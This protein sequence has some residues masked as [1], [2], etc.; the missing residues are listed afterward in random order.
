MIDWVKMHVN[1]NKFREINQLD[2]KLK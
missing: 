2:I 1:V